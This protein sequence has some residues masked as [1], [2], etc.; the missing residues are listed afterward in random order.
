MAAT[1]RRPE[2]EHEDAGPIAD[3]DSLGSDDSLDDRGRASTTGL[4]GDEPRVLPG[5]A[6]PVADPTRVLEI[7]VWITARMSWSSSPT[8]D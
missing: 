4:G 5:V 2:S 8:N 3:D 7:G 1:W 6:N